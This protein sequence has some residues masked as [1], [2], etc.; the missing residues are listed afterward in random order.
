MYICLAVSDRAFGWAWTGNG[1]TDIPSHCVCASLATRM[2]PFSWM[3][4]VCFSAFW[5]LCYCWWF[6]ICTLLFVWLIQSQC[7]ANQLFLSIAAT[8]VCTSTTLI[9]ANMG[10]IWDRQDPGGPHVGSMNFAIW[11]LS[12]MPTENQLGDHGELR[13][14][15]FHLLLYASWLFKPLHI[16]L[17]LGCCPRLYL[18]GGGS[19]L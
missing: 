9:G 2:F 3:N 5:Q 12:S 13:C 7:V 19:F 1:R 6:N 11:E 14:Q 10:P 15:C 18:W 17:W 4:T 16:K 8:F